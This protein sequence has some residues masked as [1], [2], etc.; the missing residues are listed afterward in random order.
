MCVPHLLYPARMLDNAMSTRRRG[1]VEKPNRS[2]S[3]M[4]RTEVRAA[5]NRDKLQ[6]V[7]VL[8]LMLTG[9]N[10]A[11]TISGSC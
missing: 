9:H 11:A 7:V 8:L 1:N 6:L 5:A 3:R 4:G 10:D 2:G